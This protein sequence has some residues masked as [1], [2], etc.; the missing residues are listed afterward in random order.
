[1]LEAVPEPDKGGWPPR[2]VAWWGLAL[3]VLSYAIAIVD[4]ICMG[5]LVQP[6]KASFG[7]TDT[8]VGLLQGLGFA[9]FFAAMGLPLGLLADRTNRRT[10]IAAGMAVWSIATM[11]CGLATGFA[12]MLLGRVGVGAGEATLSPAGT[13]M[14]AD[15]FPPEQRARAFAVYSLGGSMGTG[16]ALLFSG[17]VLAFADAL[18]HA[19]PGQLGGVPSWKIVFVLFGLPG[20]IM[21][22]AFL[23]TVKEPPRREGW[24]VPPRVSLRPLARQLAARPLT[25]LALIGGSAASMVATYALIGWF[26]TF[27]VRGFGW[28]PAMVAGTLGSVGLPCGVA[29]SLAGGWIVSLVGRWGRRDAPVL[30]AVLAL[31][32]VAAGALIVA[33]APA[34]TIAMVGYVIMGLAMNIP[35]IGL[36]TALNA[37]TPNSL[38]GQTLAVLTLTTNLL[39][40]T[41]GPF[42]VGLLSDHVFTTPRGVGAALGAVVIL[43]C[44]ASI[45]LLL[46]GRRSI[47]TDTA[48]LTA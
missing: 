44:A 8:Q 6:I 34:P 1:M 21:A 36:L 43:A 39:S 22:P 23:L 16:I 17:A 42:A 45:T 29:S 32:C 9:L 14:I 20:L 10:L 38:R 18:I 30:V 47:A 25:Y 33:V 15:Y 46:A 41:I 28:S 35:F 40:Q 26:P 31:A 24:T 7:F 19:L 3:L 11:A 12:G 37:V 4:R 48:V 2:R 27:M 5:L 13:S